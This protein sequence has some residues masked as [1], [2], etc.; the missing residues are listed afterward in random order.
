[1]IFL[2]MTPKAQNNKSKSK[3][4][5]L[6]Q[7]KKLLRNKTDDQHHEKATYRMGADI[8]KPHVR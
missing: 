7:T 5:G 1:M 6:D 8:C 2:A 4:V 3:Q